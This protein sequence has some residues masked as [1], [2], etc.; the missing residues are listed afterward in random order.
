MI[1]N[2]VKN[3]SD[4]FIDFKSFF[5]FFVFFLNNTKFSDAWS[6]S[7]SIKSKFIVTPL[8]F[9]LGRISFDNHSRNLPNVVTFLVTIMQFLA[10]KIPIAI[11][12]ISSNI[13]TARF[14][15]VKISSLVPLLCVGNHVNR[16]NQVV[17]Y[18]LLGLGSEVIEAFTKG[19][20]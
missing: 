7:S 6:A 19:Q 5:S 15:L 10:G 2:A 8:L 14:C 17:E 18:T 4:F 1:R 9:A 16:F 20:Q 12:I 3:C 11:P 13:P